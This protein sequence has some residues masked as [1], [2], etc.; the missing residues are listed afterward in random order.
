MHSGNEPG[1][2]EE[3]D[4]EGDGEKLLP[5]LANS[6]FGSSRWGIIPGFLPKR[7]AAPSD[8]VV[9]KSLNPHTPAGIDSEETAAEKPS[10]KGKWGLEMF[11]LPKKLQF[12]A[13]LQEILGESELDKTCQETA[14]A[15][16]PP[17][18]VAVDKTDGKGPNAK[19]LKKKLHSN[20]D[21]FID[22]VTR[23]LL[24]CLKNHVF[25]FQSLHLEFPLGISDSPLLLEFSRS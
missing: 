11:R 6:K 16:P 2:E 23:V 13:P 17:S 7:H 19:G 10:G 1:D 8:A 25:F 5:S 9:V 4:G 21:F 14:N 24:P 18:V 3:H 12:D 22:K 15:G 20:P